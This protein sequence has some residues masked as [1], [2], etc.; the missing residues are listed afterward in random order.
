VACAQQIASGKVSVIRNL[1]K[2]EL[3][4]NDKNETTLYSDSFF[5]HQS[6]GSLATARVILKELTD[7]APIRSIVDVGCGVGPWLRA[8]LELGVDRVTGLDGDY[9]DRGRLLVEPSLF[10]PCDLEKD[11]LDQ[12]VGFVR[13][14]VAISLEVAE[15]LSAER[16]R[17]FV[18]ELCR[19]SDL[20]LF[21]AAIPGQG[22]S[23]HI[24]EQWP[25]YWAALFEQHGCACFDVVRPRVWHRD[26]CEWWYLQNALLFARRGTVAFQVASRLG[27]PIVGPAMR[28]VH[29]R[30]LQHF[31]WRLG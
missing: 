24:N 23:N 12:A 30:M 26:E 14:D 1:L 7:F 20:F 15:H 3:V 21:S 19:L 4:M 18:A 29:P 6:A 28:L 31:G 13:F 11:R 25:D 9:V 22:G 10:V 17:S 16:A 8:A 5:D 2:E 27:A